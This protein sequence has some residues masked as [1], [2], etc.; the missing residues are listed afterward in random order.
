VGDTLLSKYYEYLTCPRCLH[1]IVVDDN[2][3]R[4]TSAACIY[5]AEPFPTVAELPALFD[6]QNSII[7]AEQLVAT[8]GAPPIP[9]GLPIHI[10]ANDLIPSSIRQTIRRNTAYPICSTC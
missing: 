7:S 4:C 9:G 10:S 1:Q 8:S 2:I 5:S 6:F 3:F